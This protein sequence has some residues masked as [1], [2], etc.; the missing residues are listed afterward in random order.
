MF[1]F[2]DNKDCQNHHQLLDYKYQIKYAHNEYLRLGHEN[3]RRVVRKKHQD[4][5]KDPT[6]VPPA[7][8]MLASCPQPTARDLP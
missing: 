5:R 2:I 8:G 6:L 7:H 3:L 4:D 1:L